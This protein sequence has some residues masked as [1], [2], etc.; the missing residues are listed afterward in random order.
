MACGKTLIFTQPNMTVSGIYTVYPQASPHS[1][2]AYVNS[3]WSD[4]WLT[5]SDIWAFPSI[6]RPYNKA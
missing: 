5:V 1:Y 4:F 2:A 6:N 3:L